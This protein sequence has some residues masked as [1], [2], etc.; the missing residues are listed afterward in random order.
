[1][2]MRISCKRLLDHDPIPAI[3]D[4][5]PALDH[6]LICFTDRCEKAWR[7]RYESLRI[8]AR[9]GIVVDVSTS[10]GSLVCAGVS[11]HLLLTASVF[12]KVL[13]RIS[14][15]TSCIG[16]MDLQCDQHTATFSAGHAQNAG[17]GT[18]KCESAM[19][20]LCT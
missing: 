9:I 17:A 13:Y 18:A 11:H 15:D 20:R 5:D 10:L 1:M 14:S 3:F 19:H 8:P 6:I 12:T 16:Q 4:A 7:Q 2:E